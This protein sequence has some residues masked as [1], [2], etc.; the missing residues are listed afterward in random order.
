MSNIAI[1][2]KDEISR[3]ARK[4]IKNQTKAL[5]KNATQHRK[6]VAEMKRRISNLEQKVAIL[7][8]Q[9]GSKILSDVSKEDAEGVRFSARGLRSQRKRL[10]LSAAAYGKIV[11]VTGKAVY[12]WENEETRPRKQQRAALAALRRMGK[13]EAQARVEELVKKGLKK[14]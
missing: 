4:E 2:L 5:R 13:R 12:L 9:V 8:K 1:A 14:R 6:A 10:G 11:G 7:K 3:L